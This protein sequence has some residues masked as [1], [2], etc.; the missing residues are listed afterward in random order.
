VNCK[1]NLLL[2]RLVGAKMVVFPAKTDIPRSQQVREVQEKMKE[3]V[4]KLR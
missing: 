2:S 4:S 3:Y 1:A